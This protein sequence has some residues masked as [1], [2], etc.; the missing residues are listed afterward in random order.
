MR[1]KV[2]KSWCGPNCQILSKKEFFG[3]FKRKIYVPIALHCANQDFTNIL[4]RD[5]EI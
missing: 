1:Y 3:K 2:G 5:H 4:T